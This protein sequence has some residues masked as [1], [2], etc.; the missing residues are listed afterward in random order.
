[1][2]CSH[3][4][5]GTLKHP[6]TKSFSPF[7]V[8]RLPF[9]YRNP[10]GYL[11]AIIIHFL[12]IWYELMIGACVVSFAFGCYFFVIAMS[13]SIKASLFAIDRSIGDKID[14]KLMLDQLVE[15]I[16]LRATGKQL[17]KLRFK[18]LTIPHKNS[19]LT[20]LL[21]ISL[22]FPSSPISL[23]AGSSDILEGLITVLCLWSLVTIC[24]ALLMIQMQLV[25]YI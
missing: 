12:M 15:F 22:I 24:G 4:G 14:E 9:D 13:K 17:R 18:F 10:V 16:D 2:V 11:I 19:N 20:F 6:N 1:M 8:Q 23:V 21:R 5:C 3:N 7:S 25:P